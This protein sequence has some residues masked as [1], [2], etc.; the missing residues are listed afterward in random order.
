M[1]TLCRPLLS[2]IPVGR[3][4]W[5]LKTCIYCNRECWKMDIEP[6]VLPPGWIAAC[7]ECAFRRS[8][9]QRNM[10]EKAAGRN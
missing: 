9:D 5:T 1:M 8:W 6:P 10:D 2:N 3:E 4:G 7:T